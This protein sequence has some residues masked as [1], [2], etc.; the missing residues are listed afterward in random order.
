[1]GSTTADDSVNLYDFSLV[2]SGKKIYVVFS[3]DSM[4]YANASDKKEVYFSDGHT[5]FADYSRLG[6]ADRDRLK[7]IMQY[8]QNNSVM[9]KMH[10]KADGSLASNEVINGKPVNIYGMFTEKL[11]PFYRTGSNWHYLGCLPGTVNVFNAYSSEDEKNIEVVISIDQNGNLKQV[12]RRDTGA[13][14]NGRI[15]LYDKYQIYVKNGLPVTG[16]QKIT[17]LGETYNYYFDPDCAVALVTR[18]LF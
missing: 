13:K 11:S 4:V 1:D 15:Q 12:C 5:L 18:S 7:I 10:M 14:L 8:S 6:A 17:Y 16:W 3:E 9:L 2:P